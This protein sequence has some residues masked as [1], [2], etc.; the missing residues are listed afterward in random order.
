MESKNLEYWLSDNHFKSWVLNPSPEEEAFFVEYLKENP[1]EKETM[2]KARLLLLHIEKNKADLSENEIS[3]QWH[4]LKSKQKMPV[5][6]RRKT[7][8]WQIAVAASVLIISGLSIYLWQ[9]LKSEP[10]LFT[11]KFNETKTLILPDSSE[12]TLNAN[13]QLSMNP[14]WEEGNPREVWLK[15]EGYFKVKKKTQKNSFEVHTDKLNIKVLGTIFNVLA[16]KS[17]NNVMLEE[18]KVEVNT[19][20]FPSQ[21]MKP[22]ELITWTDK[23]LIKSTVSAQDYNA[24]LRNLLIFKGMELK[25]VVARLEDLYGLQIELNPKLAQKQFTA[26]LPS[27]NPEVVLDALV[28]AFGLKMRKVENKIIL[29]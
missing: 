23:A 14:D 19:A 4:A 27:Q 11:T 20:T 8:W 24:W 9:N 25:N 1:T 28:A 26:V 3:E 18:G 15:G 5:I 2:A 7:Q 6:I 29:E 17:V 16:R 13:S 12:V 21:L 10:V 22:N